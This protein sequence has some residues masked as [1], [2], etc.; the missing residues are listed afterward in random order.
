MNQDYY[1]V[2]L[3]LLRCGEFLCPLDSLVAGCELKGDNE[4]LAPR[5][6]LELVGRILH[7]VYTLPILASS[8][9]VLLEENVTLGADKLGHNS[10]AVGGC[11]VANVVVTLRYNVGKTIVQAAQGARNGLPLL[12]SCLVAIVGVGQSTRNLLAVVLNHIARKEGSL[13]VQAVDVVCN[14]RS[15]QVKQRLV[16]GKLCIALWVGYE[17]HT[18]R[19]LILQACINGNLWLALLCG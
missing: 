6:I 9:Q 4:H 8:D 12:T 18:E 13:D 17:N 5:L 16:Y 1:L 19:I 2:V 10:V 11:D 7:S 15:L 14:P 3:V